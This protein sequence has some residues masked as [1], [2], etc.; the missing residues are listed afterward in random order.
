MA[1][2]CQ[3]CG[4]IEEGDVTF[5][6]TGCGGNNVL[7]SSVSMTCKDCEETEIVAVCPNC[8]SEELEK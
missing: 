3:F 5:R 8:G 4:E 2:N 6:C 1:Y 7:R